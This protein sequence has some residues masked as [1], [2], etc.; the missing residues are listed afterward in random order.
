MRF[1]NTKLDFP[2]DFFAP[3]VRCGYE[4]SEKNKK[5]WAILLD[6][7]VELERV[8]KKYNIT[9]YADAGT[10]LGTVRHQGFIPWDDDIDIALKRK[11]YEKLCKVASKEFKHPYFFQTAYTDDHCF[12][13]HAQLRNTETT[14]IV[15]LDHGMPYN[16][17]I[18]IDI[19]P[20]IFL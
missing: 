8:C 16:K 19:F 17:G 5:V 18:F 12:R 20:N 10:L 15:F 6:L 14:G 9:M 13:G 7:V 1:Y 4:V 2:D 11:D 3:E